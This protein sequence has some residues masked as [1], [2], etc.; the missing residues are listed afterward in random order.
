MGLVEHRVPRRAPRVPVSVPG[1]WRQDEVA[2]QRECGERRAARLPR[3]LQGV[4]ASHRRWRSPAH[5]RAE[6]HE[7]RGARPGC[8]PAN[9][10]K[11]CRG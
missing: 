4:V 2:P 10:P 1:A 11:D 6:A 7:R 8:A 9:E 5:A 3:W